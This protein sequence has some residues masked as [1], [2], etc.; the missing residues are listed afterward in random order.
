MY[1]ES[2]MTIDPAQLTEIH[3]IKPTKGFARIANLLT[4]GIVKSQEERE[5]FCAVTILQQIN[6]VM[7]STGIHNIV[8]LAK[9]DTVIYEDVEG[10][11]NDLKQAVDE[12]ASHIATEDR[13][14]FDSMNL[15][16]EHEEDELMV[17]IDIHINRSHEVG[18]HPIE[19]NINGLCT[20]LDVTEDEEDI[21]QSMANIFKSQSNYD[22]FVDARKLSFEKLVAKIEAGFLEH[23][24]LDDV[25]VQSQVNII[26][27][28][29]RVKK[30]TD[31][32]RSQSDD[33]DPVYMDHYGWDDHSYYA[34]IWAEH[35]HANE[36]QCQNVT[37]VDS[38]GNGVLAVNETGFA[39]SEGDTMNVEA[40][41]TLPDSSAGESINGSEFDGASY[42]AST[43][44]VTGG[45][46]G[47]SDGGSSK[48][49]GSGGF[50]SGLAD[51][52]GSMA[53]SMCGGGDGG[54]GSCGGG[55]GC[56]GGCGGG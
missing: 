43:Q 28:A 11:E 4:A 38:E 25:H 48:D 34:W 50:F 39:A 36:I 26:R 3:R 17:L 6:I 15:I 2:K 1:L 35:C 7:R 24:N 30:R 40:D 32:P 10:R 31:I 54:G 46:E 13:K 14:V 22:S 51:S 52:L 8:R 21:Q 55:G 37:I 5:T 16:L 41:F 42:D 20:R 27:P 47:S 12:F 19:I 49:G 44:T 9:D 23:M 33:V 56:G 45:G 29:S 18:E 53:D